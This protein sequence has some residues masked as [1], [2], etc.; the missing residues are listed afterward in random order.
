VIVIYMGL[1]RIGAIAQI[2]IEA[3]RQ[4]DTPVAIVTDA[5]LPTQAVL[6]TTLGRVRDDLAACPMPPPALICIGDTV[7]ILEKHNG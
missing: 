6:Q 2:L 1:K 4:A 5:S 3:G 7:D